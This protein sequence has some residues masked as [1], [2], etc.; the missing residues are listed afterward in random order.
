MGRSDTPRFRRKGLLE[1]IDRALD[2][3]PCDLLIVHRDAEREPREKRVEEIRLA[4][5]ARAL[6]PSHQPAVCVVPVRMTEAWLLFDEATIRATV[7][8]PRGTMTLS[9]QRL[10]DIEST[11]DPKALL[12][13]ALQVASEL[14]GRRLVKFNATFHAHRVAESIT[15]YSPLRYLAA[16]RALENE[17]IDTLTKQHWLSV[18]FFC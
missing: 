18:R 13:T 7:G 14:R 17:L 15:D 1:R 2:L 4:L 10:R 6:R 11:P 12:H 5:S 16:F 8:V 9:L 3:F